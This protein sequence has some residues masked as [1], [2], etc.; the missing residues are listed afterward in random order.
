MTNTG[1]KKCNILTENKM[2]QNK[3]GNADMNVLIT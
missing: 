1:N 2:R 3:I